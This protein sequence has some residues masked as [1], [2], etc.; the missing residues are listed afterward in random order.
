MFWETG[1][2]LSYNIRFLYT[3]SGV[4]KSNGSNNYCMLHL[5]NFT[6]VFVKYRPFFEFKHVLSKL[7]F[8]KITEFAENL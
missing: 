5:S 3:I 6:M 4:T 7:N 1:K 8:R 2:D